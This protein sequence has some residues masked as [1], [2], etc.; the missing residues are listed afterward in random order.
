M[1][2]DDVRVEAG[3]RDLTGF[4]ERADQLSIDELRDETVIE[5]IFDQMQRELVAR[6]LVLLEGPRGCGKTH[7]MRY[8]ELTCAEDPSKPLA[9][10]VSFNRYLRLE[11]LLTI[12]SDALNLFQA[13]A[14]GLL[15]RSVADKA[16]A[17]AP[18]ADLGVERSFGVSREALDGLVAT[19]ER[20][21]PPS[22]EAEAV[23]AALT[24]DDVLAYVRLVCAAA[25]RRRTVLLLDDAAL[26]LS[27]DLLIEFFDLLRTLKAHDVSPKASV[28]PGTTEYGPRFHADH[29]GRRIKAWLPIDEP[30]YL[31]V[32]RTIA[33]IRLQG[34]A[35]VP[36]DVDTVLMY[37][38]F[39]IPRAYLSLLRE[40]SGRSGGR[41]QAVLNEVVRDHRDARIAEYRSLAAK[42]PTL[43]TLVRTGERVFEVSVS[44]LSA[45][46]RELA[47]RGEK[48]LLI[49]LPTADLGPMAQR[50]LS[51]L[52]EVGL[53]RQEGEVSHGEGRAYSRLM[54]HLGA[55]VAERAFGA[56]RGGGARR[57]AEA[58]A[59]PTTKH[60]L[61]RSLTS[62]IGAEMVAAGLHLD[63][64][65]C[66]KCGQRRL[67]PNQKFCHNCGTKLLDESTFERCMRLPVDDVPGLSDFK[68]SS[69]RAQAL[70]TIGDIVALPDPG[71]TIRRSR[72]MG[73]VRTTQVIDTVQDYVDEFLS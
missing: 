37:A 63:E 42:L 72:G 17:L 39:G 57:I 1:D 22:S 55:L 47:A 11:P 68:R 59:R 44:E 65:P 73:S 8:A 35:A 71:T 29:E 56:G 16:A 54:P 27:R 32:M 46:N 70:R 67:S 40:W 49:G 50:M 69:L 18:D 6:G 45:A 24:V 19:L 64:P 48:Q 12:R 51:L 13:W 36:E 25:G 7:M 34:A 3:D 41:G 43:A 53:L 66:Q 15:V 28:Y 33:R 61:R 5:D 4:E 38:A 60:P 21:R 23:A 58:L 30:R 31:D 9:V 14:L 52:V 62:L 10:Y 2:G 26:T 20:G